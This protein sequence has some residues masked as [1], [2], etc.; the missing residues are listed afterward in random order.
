M[1]IIFITTQNPYLS[2]GGLALYSM[3]IIEALKLSFPNAHIQ[4]VAIVDSK[5][6]GPKIIK[7]DK[8]IYIHEVIGR[9][10][11]VLK[12]LH[13][14]IRRKSYNTLRYLDEFKIYQNEINNADMLILNHRLSLGAFDLLNIDKFNGKLVYINHNDEFSSISSIAKYVSNPILAK[15]SLLEAKKVLDDEIAVMN[16]S[17]AV[18]FIN[19]DDSIIYQNVLNKFQI[20]YKTIPIYIDSIKTQISKKHENNFDHTKNILLVGSF[21]WLPKK[22]N[23]EWLS[24]N[25]F[26]IVLKSFPE[27]RLIIVG[28]G[29]DQLKISNKSVYVYSDV[30][31]VDKYYSKANIFAIP[32]KQSGG[33]KIKSLEAAS[34]GMAIISTK[35]GISGSMLED[36]HECIVC[37]MEAEE[38]AKA[39]IGLI[40]NPKKAKKMGQKAMKKVDNYFSEQAVLNSWKNFWSEL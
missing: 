31:D 23:A 4:V 38:F 34:K 20:K 14:V 1:K 5:I 22:L 9:K 15:L 28:R 37:E 2:K 17:N 29:A 25:V 33:L 12:L 32:E 16:S 40:K 13:S 6:D 3:Q 7:I 26:P 36:G 19:S 18:T 39:I 24:N 21:D 10:R 30:L 27:S 11:N 8:N 35:F